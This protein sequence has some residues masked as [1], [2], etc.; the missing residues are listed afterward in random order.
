MAKRSTSVRKAIKAMTMARKTAPD[1]D[2]LSFSVVRLEIAV[3]DM[4]ALPVV[5]RAPAAFAERR[6]SRLGADRPRSH[7]VVAFVV[8]EIC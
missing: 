6:P 1:S 3:A 4:M 5:E 8:Q 2:C 7:V